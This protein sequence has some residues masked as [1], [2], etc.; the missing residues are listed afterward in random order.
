MYRYTCTV[1]GDTRY[2]EDCTLNTTSHPKCDSAKF[3]L[4][5]KE[6]V[7]K[8]VHRYAVGELVFFGANGDDSG[9]ITELV[10]PVN[11]L[12]PLGYEIAGEGFLFESSI[13]Y[14]ESELNSDI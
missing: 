4:W 3:G 13:A 5:T 14:S 6:R 10:H 11:Q 2:S 9:V 7:T 8:P 1:C 12:A